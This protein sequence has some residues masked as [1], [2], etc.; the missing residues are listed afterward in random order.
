MEPQHE[1]GAANQWFTRMCAECGVTEI[2]ID[3]RK[4][5]TVDAAGQYQFL[6]PDS[7]LG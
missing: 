7:R 2:S 1:Q 6:F 4:E 5:A 3:N